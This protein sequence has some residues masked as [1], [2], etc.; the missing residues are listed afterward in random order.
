MAVGGTALA[1]SLGLNWATCGFFLG[2]FSCLRRYPL[3]RRFYA[4]KR[5]ARQPRA[6]YLPQRFSRPPP[7]PPPPP[8]P[9]PRRVAPP[10]PRANPWICA[11]LPALSPPPSPSSR[12]PPHRARSFDPEVRTKPRRLPNGLASWVM[13]VLLCPEDD[14][15]SVAGLDVAVFLRLLEYGA[16]LFAFVSLWCC[17]V[18]LP[19]NATVG[20]RGGAGGQGEAAARRSLHRGWRARAVQRKRRLAPAP[21][22]TPAPR[23]RARAGAPVRRAAT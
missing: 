21:T 16:V 23:A 15:V 9:S 4:P 20:A 6:L 1:T 14:V 19:V 17:V 8:P 10:P 3:T 7:P 11:A 13:P 18:L 12:P 5:C 22:P 2:L